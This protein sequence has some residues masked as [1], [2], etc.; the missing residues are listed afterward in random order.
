LQSISSKRK[1]I[2]HM[3]I[4]IEHPASSYGLPVILDDDGVVIDYTAGV[5]KIRRRLKLKTR[6][7]AEK[8]GVSFRT[9]ESWENGAM[10][11]AQALNALSL[12]D[13][14]LPSPVAALQGG[15]QCPRLPAGTISNAAAGATETTYTY[16]QPK[17]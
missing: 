1:Q 7:L 13:L 12:L 16:T 15:D 4:T 17:D 11:G 2:P 9:V 14:T 3:K 10:P 6:Q 5:R 8:L